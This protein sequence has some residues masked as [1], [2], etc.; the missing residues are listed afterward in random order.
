MRETLR[1]LPKTLDETY[2][3]ILVGIS[4][5]DRVYTFRTLQWLV[6]SARPVTINE[7]A[8]AM[9]VNLDC[10]LPYVDRDRALRDPYDLLDICPGLVRL[11]RHGKED[12]DTAA[13]DV[14]E[15]AHFSVKEY[16]MSPRIQQGP[17]AEFGLLV[18]QAHKSLA[19]CCL[20]HLLTFECPMTREELH[21]HP[22][23]LYSGN[24][25]HIHTRKIGQNCDTID[26][27]GTMLLSPGKYCFENCLDL[28]YEKAPFWDDNQQSRGTPLY[29]MALYGIV[30]LASTL[31]RDGVDVNAKSGEYDSAL[32]AA[33]AN[34]HVE[35]VR[36]L[37]D[38]GADVN[39]QGG[40]YD[41]ALQVA[42][43]R[44]HHEVVRLLLDHGADVNA[45]GGLYDNVLQVASARGHHEVV[46]LLLDHGADGNAQGGHYG[47]ALQAA[48][49][50]G[51]HEV[52]R[53]L[54]DHGADAN[55]E[56]GPYG[57]ALQAAS[58]RDH[59]EAVRLLLDHR[60]DFNA[61]GGLYANSLHAAM[62]SRQREGRAAVAGPW[63]IFLFTRL[64]SSPYTVTQH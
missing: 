59:L 42:S 17:A 36:L 13:K 21:A 12:D 45:Q 60:A 1:S 11:S 26:R 31:I 28:Y 27:L 23:A 41:N 25:W 46:R 15:L 56:G 58:A 24:F 63:G 5:V 51:H 61:Q 64:I 6:F 18:S 8:E 14:L 7:V 43:A 50:Q 44:G 52:V 35:V 30:S 22:L 4:E 3:R 29:Y 48:S 34:G 62:A 57:N 20:A 55:A 38:H 49:V 2:D 32:Q 54:L 10:D 16:L 9:V 33:S 47:N 53:L 39:A 37:L 40:L 19:E